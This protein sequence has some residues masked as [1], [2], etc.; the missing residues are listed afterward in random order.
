MSDINSISALDPR[1]IRMRMQTAE[2]DRLKNAEASTEDL[3]AA[4]ETDVDNLLN[5]FQNV[6]WREMMKAMRST[7]P[8]SELFKRS[9]GEEIFQSML[10]DEYATAIGGGSQGSLGLTELLKE[11]LGLAQTQEVSGEDQPDSAPM[12]DGGEAVSGANAAPGSGRYAFPAY[13]PA[14]PPEKEMG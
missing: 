5:E 14:L 8:E 13:G 11:Q 4:S 2:T 3:K 10:D 12:E 9:T 7:V 6:L 1:G